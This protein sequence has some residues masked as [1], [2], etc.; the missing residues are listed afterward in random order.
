MK[1]SVVI[2]NYNVKYFLEQCLCSVIKACDNIEAEIFVIDN[3]SSDGS[4]EYLQHKF[5][6][7][8]FIW[9]ITN[10]G[11]AKA[12]NSV[13]KS[14][15]G[16]Y[17][18]FLNPD[19]IVPEDCFE[20]CINFISSK[21]LCGA[22][23]VHMIDGSGY[24]L[25]ESKRSF[26]WP[27]TALYKMLGL[28]KFFPQ[29]KVFAKYYATHLPELETNEVEVLPGAF[30]MLPGEAL[31]K[32]GGFDED[33]FMYGED[34]DLSYRLQK[35]GFKNYYFPETSIIHYKGE[36]TQKQSPFYIKQFYGAMHLFV[37]KHFSSRKPPFYLMSAAIGCSML[38]AYTRLLFTKINFLSTPDSK[39]KKQ[40]S[41][42]LIV[43]RQ[44]TFND[45]IQLLKYAA[46]PVVIA[47]RITVY[48]HDDDA[49]SGK[50]ENIAAIIQKNN[51][52][53]VLFCEG[54]L[55]YKVII[56][57]MQELKGKVLF[58]IHSRQSRSVTGSSSRETNGI[59]I[60][61]D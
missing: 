42:L 27:S 53:Q 49:S 18:L 30:M 22:L 15:S 33:F 58:L 6:T 25:K 38:L 39:K 46:K 21:P 51:I 48:D 1:L 26:P 2:V 50:L 35:A 43:A 12:S 9:N 61:K 28:A 59:F 56:Q 17:V 8:Q 40:A 34:I 23:G 44:T 20:L 16:E 10:A 45:M 3:R 13:L 60:A 31:K 7:V 57:H 14:I 19:T 4:R 41:L 24:F 54:D 11:F 5:S 47:G 29:S 32:T 36:S 37:K 52:D 55:S